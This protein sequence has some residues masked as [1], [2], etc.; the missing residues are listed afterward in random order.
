LCGRGTFE[1]LDGFRRKEIGECGDLTRLDEEQFE[2]VEVH[3]VIGIGVDGSPHG[4]FEREP[5]LAHSRGRDELARCLDQPRTVTLGPHDDRSGHDHVEMLGAVD[6]A[7]EQRTGGDRDLTS[8]Q[9]VEEVMSSGEV[10]GGEAA[11]HD[12]FK[13]VDALVDGLVAQD[14]SGVERIDDLYLR[15][16]LR[17]RCYCFGIHTHPTLP[18]TA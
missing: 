6:L 16:H 7:G 2:L 15:G 13:A 10:D 1:D 3:D 5:D 18:R 14:G 12:R 11:P 4:V 17:G 9:A 8:V